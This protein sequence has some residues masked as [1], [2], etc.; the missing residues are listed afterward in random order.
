MEL[1]NRVDADGSG[2]IDYSE[3]MM[4]AVT[5]EKLLTKDKLEQA[6]SLFDKNGDKQISYNE[7]VVLLNSVKSLDAEAVERAVREV[8]VKGRG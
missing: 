8:D 5:K 2:E 1:I 6:F 7:V 3:W 4:T